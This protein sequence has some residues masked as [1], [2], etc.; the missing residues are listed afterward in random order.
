MNYVL[1]KKVLFF[2]EK[3]ESPKGDFDWAAKGR[4]FLRGQGERAARCTHCTLLED[5]RNKKNEYNLDFQSC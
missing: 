4:F 2:D 1:E 5:F 3:Q